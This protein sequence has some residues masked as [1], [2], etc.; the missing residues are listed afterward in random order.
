LN[1]AKLE[2]ER[3]LSALSFTPLVGSDFV[4]VTSLSIDFELDEKADAM[5]EM[6]AEPE[7]ACRSGFEYTELRFR[8]HF[9]YGVANR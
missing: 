5:R 1:N 9:G 4:F 3:L 8:D 2:S 6:I 7:N